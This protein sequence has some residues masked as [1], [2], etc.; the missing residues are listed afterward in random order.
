MSA[1]KCWRFMGEY[2]RKL[3]ISWLQM[4]IKTNLPYGKA[5]WMCYVTTPKEVDPVSNWKIGEFVRKEGAL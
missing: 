5:S 4:L 2:F 1:K 3:S